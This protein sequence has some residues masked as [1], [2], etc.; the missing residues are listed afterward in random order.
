[1]SREQRDDGGGVGVARGHGTERCRQLAANGLIGILDAFQNGRVN[2]MLRF[3][4][5]SFSDAYRRE[6]NVA[7]RIIQ[8]VG[9]H[10][11][12]NGVNPIERP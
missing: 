10:G 1:M 4:E 5:P 6:A 2:R 12:L 8:R 9:H 11:D 3:A 7:R